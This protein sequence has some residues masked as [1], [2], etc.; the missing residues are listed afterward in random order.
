[1]NF[2]PWISKRNACLAHFELSPSLPSNR[3]EDLATLP[4]Q[5]GS[6][7]AARNVLWLITLR[8]VVVGVFLAVEAAVVLI[9]PALRSQYDIEVPSRWPWILALVLGLANICF[10]IHARKLSDALPSR[11]SAYLNIWTQIIADLPS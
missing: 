10:H 9:G 2:D 5:I 8:W 3:P 1:V 11:A 4:G 6:E 7:V